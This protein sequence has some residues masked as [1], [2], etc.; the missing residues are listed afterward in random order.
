MRKG[1]VQKTAFLA[2][3]SR[4]AFTAMDS[5]MGSSG[6]MTLVMIIVQFSSSLKRSRSGFCDRERQHQDK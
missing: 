6:G 3:A 5:S 4:E 2:R 1:S